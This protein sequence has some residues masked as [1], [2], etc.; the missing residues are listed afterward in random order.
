MKYRVGKIVKFNMVD[1]QLIK[2]VNLDFKIKPASNINGSTTFK[3]IVQG[4]WVVQF[5]AWA[6]LGPCTAQA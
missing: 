3:Y 4:W 6:V 1:L 2:D 5:R